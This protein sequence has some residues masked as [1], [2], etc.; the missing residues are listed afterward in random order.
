[1]NTRKI[2]S[3]KPLDNFRLLIEC[4]KEMRV[5]DMKT[6]PLLSFFRD[7][8][9]DKKVFNTVRLDKEK[10]IITWDNEMMLE[11][12][13]LYEHGVST[14]PYRE[15]FLWRLI[16]FWCNWI[17]DPFLFLAPKFLFALKIISVLL[18]W[19]MLWFLKRGSIWLFDRRTRI[20]KIIGNLLFYIVMPLVVVFVINF[21]CK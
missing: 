20:L 1:M 5:V 2:L 15:S 14:K 19:F 13:E 10:G 3:V 17:R 8:I 18:I 21:F 9:R 12:D 6:Y 11:N 4:E 7:L 16:N